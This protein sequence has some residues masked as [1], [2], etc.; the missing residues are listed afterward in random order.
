M[1][2]Y[3]IVIVLMIGTPAALQADVGQDT[4]SSAAQQED[5][6]ADIDANA[7]HSVAPVMG[8]EP[9]F[10]FVFG[11]AYFF[12]TPRISF[13]V[14]ANTNLKRVYQAH[15]AFIHR[16]QTRWEYGLKAGATQGYDPFYGQ[17][18]ETLPE[19]FSR[20][21][22]INSSNR[23]HI[24]Y[25][26][27][28]IFS[29][30]AFVDSRIRTEENGPG[31]PPSGRL[32]PDETSFGVGIFQKIDT[33]ERKEDPQ[34]GFVFGTEFAFM[35]G[36]FSSMTGRDGFSQLQGDFIV[37][38]EILNGVV[39]EVIAAFQLMGGMTFGTPTYAYNYRLGGANA[40]RGYLENRFRGEK[41][42][43]QQTELRFP[44]FQPLSG[45]AFLGFGDATDDQFTN[46][47]LAY[48]VGIRIGLPPDFINKIRIDLGF[49]RDQYGFFANFGQTF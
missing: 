25:K 34:E 5:R 29:F 19:D 40:M 4:V 15:G 13:G 9:T 26:P 22:G 39:P 10:G 36:S 35:P 33:R 49:G 18:G 31:S 42:Y 46:P 11:A 28:A 16:F 27:T 6:L 14:D 32:A 20:L 38:K 8:Y 41:F 2:V 44:I 7:G 43:L 12:S 21:W 17:G 23:I 30:G 45:A 37:Y 24:A 47:K 48:G 1:M 3:L